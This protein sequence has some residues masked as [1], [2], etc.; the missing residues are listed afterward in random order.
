MAGGILLAG[1]LALE[2]GLRF[3]LFSPFAR[4]HGYGWQLRNEALYT[5]REAGRE[6]WALRAAIHGP[7]PRSAEF[8]ERFGWLPEDIDRT[9]LA[10]PDEA[11]LGSRRP[12]LLYGDSYARCV[13]EA[14][15]CWG[16]L[17]ERSPLAQRFAL[18]NYGVGGFGLGQIH[19]LMQATLARFQERDPLVVIGIL[20]DDD[21]DRSYLPFRSKPKPYFTLEGDELVL[22]PLEHE[23]AASWLADNPPA[24]RSFLWRWVLFGSGLVPRRAA[25]ALTMEADHVEEKAALNRRLLAEIQHDLERRGLEHFFVLFHARKALEA[26][27]AYAW[28]EPFLYRTFEELEIRFVS[29]K[30]FLRAHL[31]RTGT[32]PE[33]LFFAEGPGLNHYTAL[34]NEIV[35]E[36]L[37]AGIEGRFEPYAYLAER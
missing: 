28:Q 17:L 8:D 2:G 13:S 29:S 23:D 1:L 16:E 34:A 36:A 15:L 35:F 7:A 14:G 4:A 31:A 21:L 12:L 11:R 9:T 25:L 32:G 24:I 22:H 37:R 30:R 20:V 5:A 3:V 27:G 10:S 26:P 18:V 6:T 33:A 19:L